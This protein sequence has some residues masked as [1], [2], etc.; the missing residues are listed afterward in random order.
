MHPESGTASGTSAGTGLDPVPGTSPGEGHPTPEPQGPP[1]DP[2]GPAP[3]V[4][5]EP[6]N[7]AAGVTDYRPVPETRVTLP[8]AGS[9][10]TDPD[11]HTKIIRLTN[12]R[13]LGASGCVHSYSTV[14]AFNVDSSWV[15]AYCDEPRLFT[16]DKATDRPT[17]VGTLTDGQAVAVNWES[18]YWSGVSPN[19]LYVLGGTPGTRQTKLYRVDVTRHDASRF[20]VVKDFAGAWGGT[21][22]LW[23]LSHSDNDEVFTFHARDAGGNY[24]KTGAY[25]RS[26]D[27]LVTFPDGNFDV[28]ETYVQ[29]T[30]RT[31]NVIG[32]GR[33]SFVVKVW[34][35]RDNS[36]VATMTD[37][38]TNKMGGH[39]DLG[40]TYMV[41]GDRYESGAV[42][43]TWTGLT[44]PR[45]V[46]QYKSSANGDANWDIADHISMRNADESFFL[47][48]TY[49]AG[50]GR[51][52]E[53]EIILVKTNGSGFSRV[54]HTRSAGVADSYWSQPR[55]VIDRRGRYVVFTSDHGT[56]QND[57]YILKLP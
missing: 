13:D 27:R 43:R 57:V 41:N 37:S 31:I 25:L 14:P 52:F 9:S 11:F 28:D 2:K 49:G 23:Q 8:P 30:G 42:V 16:F 51:P 20:T 4:D 6:P 53:R 3:G 45:N 48:S 15:L 54:A 35:P 29:K 50:D 5:F 1:A 21:W 7:F 47:M 56:S 36:I 55:A 22:D 19:I 10:F 39:Y 38:A 33:D 18:A 17:Y 32:K 44:A 46:F 40:A 12:A 26:Q 24:Y 34:N